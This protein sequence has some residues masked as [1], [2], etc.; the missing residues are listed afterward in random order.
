L[1]FA[2][3]AFQPLFEVTAGAQTGS[4]PAPAGVCLVGL[5]VSPARCF[6]ADAARV[7]SPPYAARAALPSTLPLP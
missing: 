2:R 6:Q 3:L 5:F 7:A 1:S 4:H